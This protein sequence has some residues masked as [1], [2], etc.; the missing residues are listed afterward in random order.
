MVILGRSQGGEARAHNLP[1]T[2]IYKGS[3]AHYTWCTL[4]FIN[5]KDFTQAQKL[6][7]V[8]TYTFRMRV[9]YMRPLI[10]SSVF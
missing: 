5:L 4:A 6:A 2:G 3:F 1:L 7:F 9:L 10:F 8:R